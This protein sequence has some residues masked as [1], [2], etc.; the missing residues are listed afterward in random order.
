MT[1]NDKGAS[2]DAPSSS[3]RGGFIILSIIILIGIFGGIALGVWQVYRL[4]WKLDLI[5]RVDARVHE[6]AIP[7]PGPDGWSTLS[8]DNAEY[9]HVQVSGHYLDAPSTLVKAVT[10]YGSGYWVMSPLE[11]ARGFVVF[12]NRGFVPDT[13]KAQFDG[14]VPDTT[15]SVRVT[16]LLRMSQPGG[17]FLRDNDPE[18]GR[19]YSR[20][21]QALADKLGV[22]PVAPYFIDAAANDGELSYPIGGLTQI[23]FHNSHLV[24][25]ITWF[26]LA[27]MSL[28]AGVWLIRSRRRGA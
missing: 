10:D 21:V 16:G 13:S 14:A 8:N 11:T 4:Q 12:I 5:A 9:T 22:D 15:N 2:T 23:T 18:G 25:A 3:K 28:A 1:S 24:Y 17:A 6:N 26:G 7:A 27:L 19:W 20:D